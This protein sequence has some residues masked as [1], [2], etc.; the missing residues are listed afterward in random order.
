[1]ALRDHGLHRLCG[2]VRHLPQIQRLQSQLDGAAARANQIAQILD[3]TLRLPDLAV[4]HVR[5]R[6]QPY[7]VSCVTSQHTGAVGK[8]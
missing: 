1:M 2:E 6:S 7:V 8:H 5:D 4:D 3:Q